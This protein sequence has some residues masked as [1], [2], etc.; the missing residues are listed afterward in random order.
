MD[1]KYSPVGDVECQQ[2]QQ[3]AR[4]TPHKLLLAC[5]GIWVAAHIPWMA[6]WSAAQNVLEDLNLY[7]TSFEAQ[8]SRILAQTP[9]IDGHID[10]PIVLRAKHNNRIQNDDF[11]NLFENGTLTGHVDLLRLRQGQSG[12]AFWSVYM[13]CPPNNEDFSDE[14]YTHTV[15]TTFEQI[16]IMNR[17]QAEYRRDF[18]GP[19][20]SDGVDK[21]FK[22]GK[23]ISPLGVEG[24]HQIGNKASN[25]RQFYQLGA[26]YITLTHNCHNKYADAAV[27]ENPSR[28]AE[29]HWGGVSPQGREMIREMNR[30]GMIVDLAHVSEDTMRDVLCGNE[31]WQGSMAPVIFSHSSAWSIC[32]HPRNVKDHILQLV[33]KRNSVVMVTGLP[34][35]ISCVDAGNENGMPD[36][37]PANSTLRQ[38][39]RHI[40]YIGDLIGYDHVGIGTDFDGFFGPAKGFE[41]VTKYPALV[42][43]MLRLGVSRKDAAKVVGGN[44]VRV[45]KEVDA[46]AR[47]LQK[48]REPVLEDYVE[49]M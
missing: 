23:L 2:Q 6:S 27:L 49:G 40:V 28:K 30:V 11:K 8:A 35:F 9:L 44:V 32:P 36:F 39:A 33:K 21:A 37:Y 24:L 7:H 38:I 15:Q 25:V 1:T 16:D 41:D 17:L 47:E 46:I 43:E 29:P 42:A 19:I 20:N 4:R 3:P 12:G 48:A 10:L 13:P 18:S 26:R 45:W 5:F 22:A 31:E 34:D 14:Q